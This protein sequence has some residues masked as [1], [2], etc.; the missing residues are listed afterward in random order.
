MRVELDATI[1]ALRR[2]EEHTPG[3]GNHETGSGPAWAITGRHLAEREKA[4]VSST[5]SL[6]APAARAAGE[7]GAHRRR[8][9]CRRGSAP[10]RLD[11]GGATAN[12]PEYGCSQSDP[13]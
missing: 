13:Q 1:F 4:Y 11:R 8:G 2:Y 6:A 7:P 9:I 10:G 3:G 5:A 12:L